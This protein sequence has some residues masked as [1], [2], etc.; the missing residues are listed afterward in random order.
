MCWYFTN[1]AHLDLAEGLHSSK[2]T[3]RKGD[4]PEYIW[5]KNIP[6]KNKMRFSG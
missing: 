2:G 3:R 1:Y 4:D 5:G 6:V